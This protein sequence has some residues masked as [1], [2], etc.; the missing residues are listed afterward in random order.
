MKNE[1]LTLVQIHVIHIVCVLIQD[2]LC[3]DDGGGDDD[4]GPECGVN[5]YPGIPFPCC[6]GSFSGIEFFF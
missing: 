1:Q 4:D 5:T 6:D 2:V 3:R